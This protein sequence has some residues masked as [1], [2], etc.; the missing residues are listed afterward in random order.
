MRGSLV[1]PRSCR[2][3]SADTH[4]ITHTCARLL[5]HMLF[6]SLLFILYVLSQ[7]I[8]HFLID[9]AMRGLH[10]SL[11]FDRSVLRLGL[12]PQHIV[13]TEPLPVAR[14]KRPT[15][16]QAIVWVVCT[17]LFFACV[18]FNVGRLT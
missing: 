9:T 18:A 17:F 8:T 14:L 12:A 6:A 1:E 11:G 15:P 13:S 16:A 2:R 7:C 3:S 10:S 5:L 4:T